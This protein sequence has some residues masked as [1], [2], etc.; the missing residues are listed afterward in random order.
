KTT[1]HGDVLMATPRRTRAETQPHPHRAGRGG[2]C[3]TTPSGR[4]AREPLRSRLGPRLTV[5]GLA[6]P[7]GRGAY[8]DAVPH[9]AAVDAR[10]TRQGPVLVRHVCGLCRPARHRYV[11]LRP[12]PGPPPA[13]RHD[14][15]APARRWGG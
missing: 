13:E 10:G 1:D 6:S 3:R 14:R 5:R 8:D 4:T 12:A 9:R 11:R 2:I 7:G 15:V